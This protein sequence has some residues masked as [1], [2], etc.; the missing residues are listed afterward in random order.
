VPTS[1]VSGSSHRMDQAPALLSGC[2]TRTQHR[3]ARPRVSP[4][5]QHHPPQ[6]L[7]P[8]VIFVGSEQRYILSP[9]ASCVP[10]TAVCGIEFYVST[11]TESPTVQL[12]Q[13]C[14]L[15]WLENHLPVSNIPQGP[16][17]KGDFARSVQRYI[18]SPTV[19]RV[20]NTTSCGAEFCLYDCCVPSCTFGFSIVC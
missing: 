2:G 9:T 7:V 12:Y 8:G 14:L 15:E 13:H 1:S 6:A 3:L 11:V 20:S 5:C 4:P 16:G 17:P 19:H 10:P 18:L